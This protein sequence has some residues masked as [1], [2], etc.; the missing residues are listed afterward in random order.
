IDELGERMIRVQKTSLEQSQQFWEAL[1]RHLSNLSPLAVLDRGYSITFTHPEGVV[2]KEVKGLSVGQLIS[3][4]LAKG[5]L[6]SK[7]TEI[8]RKGKPEKK[9]KGEGNTQ[10]ALFKNW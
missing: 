8:E 5:D 7:I 4:R 3:S 1:S 2:V 9:L 6:I 10:G